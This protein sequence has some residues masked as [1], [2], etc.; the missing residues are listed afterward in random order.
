M[1]RCCHCIVRFPKRRAPRVE[2]A[3]RS[4]ACILSSYCRSLG[5]TSFPQLHLHWFADSKKQV[6]FVDR[7][8]S[9]LTIL[10]IAKQ[11]VREG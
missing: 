7:D 11:A 9:G 8:D 1:L 3:A 4:R 2:Q 6:C 5:G 10:A